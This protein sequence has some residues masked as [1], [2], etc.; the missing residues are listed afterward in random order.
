MKRRVLTSVVVGL[1]MAV[2]CGTSQAQSFVADS[3]FTGSFVQ[4][5]PNINSFGD[6]A[7][8]TYESTDANGSYF[9]VILDSSGTPFASPDTFGFAY[10]F[11]DTQF[12]GT[13]DIYGS[14]TGFQDDWQ[15]IG[16]F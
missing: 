8:L 10:L 1:F 2:G 6:H 15:F 7:V 3:P 9:F 13:L 5:I 12:D 16:N 11:A 14:D 4:V